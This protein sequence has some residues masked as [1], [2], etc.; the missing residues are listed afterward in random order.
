LPKTIF[1]LPN[2]GKWIDFLNDDS[3]YDSGSQ[4][5]KAYTLNQYPVFVKTGAIIPLNV[6]GDIWQHGDAKS[7]GKITFL[8]YPDSIRNYLFHKPTGKGIKYS[9]ILVSVDKI[10]G[11]ISIDS[12]T[13]EEFIFLV[14][15][16]N[17]PQQ[18]KNA[19]KW[20]YNS[21][22][23]IVQIEKAGTKFEIKLIN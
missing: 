9:D 4:I 15:W 19:G 22:K 13:K 17:P 14:K 16:L 5:E 1:R 23:K 21:E 3:I 8:I 10:H 11:K 7:N 20:N 2:T 6:T 12:E 18:I